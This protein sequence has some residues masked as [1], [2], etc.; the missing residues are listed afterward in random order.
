MTYEY[1]NKDKNEKDGEHNEERSFS[2][3]YNRKDK[4][5]RDIAVSDDYHE[6][7]YNRRDEG[8]DDDYK[9]NS[10]YSSPISTRGPRSATDLIS[11][12]QQ[13]SLNRR[14]NKNCFA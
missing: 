5:Y 11:H 7:N 4:G 2:R 14:E 12:H 1:N 13:I 6:D 3:Q 8:Y 9:G 10:V